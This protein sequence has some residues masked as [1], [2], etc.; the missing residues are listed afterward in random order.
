MID[1]VRVILAA[2]L[3]KVDAQAAFTMDGLW[4]LMA[5]GATA[6]SA[7]LIAVLVTRGETGP[8]PRRIAAVVSS[9]SQS[10]PSVVKESPKQTQLA[11]AAASPP[12]PPAPAFDAQAEDR[13]LAEAVRGLA[14]DNDELK[15]RIGVVEQ[16][17]SDVTGSI[18]Q[19]LAAANSPQPPPAAS[20]PEWPDKDA[21]M[22]PMTADIAAILAPFVPTPTQYGV[23]IGAGA[24]I[25]VLRARWAGLRT[26]HPDLFNGL[27]PA[28]TLR[29]AL[30]ANRVELRLVAGPLASADAAIALCADL[31]AY[32][33]VCQPT[34]FAGQHLALE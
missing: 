19:Q 23:D 3:K 9:S 11:L 34:V 32:R 28:V 17:M 21:P 33:L 22:P 2:A 7:L 25:P 15:S 27:Q 16:T 29:K 12:P 6:A 20:P 5:W 14:A 13:R 1:E 4:R 18:T 10:P 24:S 26:A 30:P 8:T 31:V